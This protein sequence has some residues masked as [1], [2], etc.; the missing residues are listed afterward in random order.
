MKK[1]YDFVYQPFEINKFPYE[2]LGFGSYMTYFSKFLLKRPETQNFLGAIKQTKG[3]ELIKSFQAEVLG[4]LTNRYFG[5]IS[6][7]EMVEIIHDNENYA[8]FYDALQSLRGDKNCNSSEWE[9]VEEQYKN[10]EPYCQK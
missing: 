8:G 4:N 9:K 10:R 6:F 7:L 2:T 5:K 3:E 1:A